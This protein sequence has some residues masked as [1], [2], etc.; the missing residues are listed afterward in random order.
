[1]SRQGRI[2]GQHGFALL[3]VLVMVVLLGLLM[4][5]AGSSWKD[6]V[7][8]AKEEELFWRGNQYRQAIEKFA[9]ARF[10]GGGLQTYPA[11]LEDLLRDPRSPEVRRYLRHLYPDPMTGGDWD[12]IKDPSGRIMGVRSSSSLKPFRQAGFPAGYEGFEGS[13]KY[14]DWEFEYTMSS[15]T[16]ARKPSQAQTPA[17]PQTP[18]QGSGSR[19]T[20]Q[21]AP[22]QSPTPPAS[23]KP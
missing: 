1:M 5:M 4:G 11:S 22:G 7:Q 19:S 8:R 18:A 20:G 14:S 21:A 2:R 13:E 3:T 17:Q 12:L 15:P 10:G 9:S 23:G 6:L 16:Q